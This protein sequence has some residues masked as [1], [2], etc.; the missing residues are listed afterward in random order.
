MFFATH[1]GWIKYRLFRLKHADH[2]LI[3]SACRQAIENR[4]SYRNDKEKWGTLH[5][6]DVLLLP[7]FPD[8]CPKVIRDLKPAHVI[9]RPDYTMLTFSIPFFRAGLLG[10]RSGAKQFGTFQYIDG[11]WFWNGNA[12][13]KTAHE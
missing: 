7:P 9:I 6:D 1:L 3:L 5:E 13:T 11:L 12:S 8:N 2:A 4:A 10:F